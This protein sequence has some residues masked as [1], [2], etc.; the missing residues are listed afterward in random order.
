MRPCGRAKLLLDR[1]VQRADQHVGQPGEGLAGLLGRYR[2]RQDARADQEHLL[3]RKDADAIEKVLVG[4]ALAA[5]ERSSAGRKLGFLGQRAEEARIDHRV[6]DFGKLRQTV[7]K[8]RRGAENE[9]DQRD[10]I[11]ILPQQ[12]K[13]PAAAV[14]PGEEPVEGDDGVIRIRRAG[15]MVQQHRHDLGELARARTRSCSEP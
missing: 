8:P 6:H 9:R 12:R 11:G 10:Q 2:A 7:G 15:K 14:Q 1:A 13:Q 3:L 4:F 5:S